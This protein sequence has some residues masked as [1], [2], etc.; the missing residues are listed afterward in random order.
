MKLI[1]LLQRNKI[2]ENYRMSSKGTSTSEL[3]TKLKKNKKEN[4]I[5]KYFHE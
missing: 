1:V 3:I 5:T 4:K 2:Q